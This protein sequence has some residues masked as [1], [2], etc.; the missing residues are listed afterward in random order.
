LHS[1]FDIFL[2]GLSM[3]GKALKGWYDITVP[4]KQ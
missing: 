1:L 2:G 4:M 3:T